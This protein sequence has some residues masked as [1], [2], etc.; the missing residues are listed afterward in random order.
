MTTGIKTVLR[1]RRKYLHLTM[2]EVAEAINRES[3]TYQTSTNALS[4]YEAGKRHA[5]PHLLVTHCR[6]LGVDPLPL[7]ADRGMV[8]PA[9][10]AR[11]RGDADAQ[12]AVL[13]MFGLDEFGEQ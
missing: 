7:L 4:G 11:L 12:R 9:L 2:R 6:V 13:H 8:H 10:S 1:E 5:S 3:G